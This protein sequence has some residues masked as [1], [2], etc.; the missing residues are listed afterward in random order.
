MEGVEP[1]YFNEIKKPSA[2]RVTL[3]PYKSFFRNFSSEVEKFV[4]WSSTQVLPDQVR[5]FYTLKK[6]TY[7][8]SL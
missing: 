4:M 1:Q 8:S 5:S 2:Y 7:D 6:F 3:Q